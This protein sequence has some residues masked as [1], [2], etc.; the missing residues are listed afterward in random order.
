MA[1]GSLAQCVDDFTWLSEQAAKFTPPIRIMYEGLSFASHRSSW[2]DAWEVIEAVN[3]P[4]LGLCLDSFNTLALEYSD[5]YA[6]S[7]VLSPHVDS[8]LDKNM[9][10]LVRRVPG[11]R[12]FFYQVA[13]SFI[14]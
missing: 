2:Q 9:E 7:G 1:N 13:V 4:N 10:D 14:F 8:L 6:E 5:P 3:L 12:I 11:D